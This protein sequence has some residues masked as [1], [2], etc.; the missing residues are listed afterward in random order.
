[1]LDSVG[2]D[3]LKLDLGSASVE[4]YPRGNDRRGVRNAQKAYVI[5]YGY[6]GKKTEKTGDKFVT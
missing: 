4:I 5:N 6:R 1:M 2:T 3:N